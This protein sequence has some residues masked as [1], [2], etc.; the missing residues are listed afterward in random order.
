MKKTL[1]FVLGISMFA[2]SGCGLLFVEGPP[3]TTPPSLKRH[4]LLPAVDS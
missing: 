1:L 2:V 3:S 4:F